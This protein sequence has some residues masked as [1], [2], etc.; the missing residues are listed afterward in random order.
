MLEK[1]KIRKFNRDMYLL[2]IDEDGTKY[3][4]QAPSWD[5]G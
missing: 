3:W 4:L 5:C 1:Q 2:G